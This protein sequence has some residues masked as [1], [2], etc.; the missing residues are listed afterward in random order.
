MLLAPSLH[1]PVKMVS[2]KYSVYL[3][4]MVLLLLC[5]GCGTKDNKNSV[6]HYPTSDTT[7]KMENINGAQTNTSSAAEPTSTDKNIQ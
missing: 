1:L 6:E 5:L 2:M 4:V 7:A 3:T